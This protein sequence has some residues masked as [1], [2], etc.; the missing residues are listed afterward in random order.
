MAGLN[1]DVTSNNED[2]IKKSNQVR[3]EIGEV[4]KQME[5]EA[6]KMKAYDSEVLKMCDNLNK[7][8]DGLLGKINTM[9]SMLQAG[10]I[11][12]D[13]P[14]INIGSASTQQLDE[15]RSKNAEL[16]EQLR[17]Q[18]EEIKQQ[19]TE[20]NNLANAIKTNNV[21]AIEQYRQANAASTMGVKEAKAELKNLT[22]GLDENIKYYEKLTQQAAAYSEELVRLQAMKDKG[23]SRVVVGDNGVSVPVLDEIDKLTSKLSEVRANQK[24]IGSEIAAQRQQQIELNAVIEKGN[25]KHV[26]TRTLIMDAREQ[27]IQMRAAGLQNTVQ[28]QR[29]AEEL[30]KM[31]RQMILVNKE[32][33]FLANPNKNL[34][35][36]KA[37][38]TG[39]ATSASLIVGVMGL[40]NEKNEKMAEIQTKVQLL[41]AVVIGLEGTYGLLKKSNTVMLAIENLQRK[42]TISSMALETK[43][44]TTNIAL[45]WAEAAAQKALNTVA[46]A[47]PYLLLFGALLTLVGGIWLLVG[48]KREEI[49][50]QKETNKIMEEQ[51]KYHDKLKSRI[52]SLISVVRDSTSTE[53]ERVMA[54]KQLQTL[55]PALFK[56][57][58]IKTLKLREQNKLKKEIN[59][60]SDYA[61]IMGAKVKA[62]QAKNRY[63]SASAKHKKDI[64]DDLIGAGSLAEKNEAFMELQL[65]QSYLKNI[66]EIKA[67]ADKLKNV[68]KVK[69]KDFW[70]DQK[71]SAISVLDAIDS[72]QR[73]LLDE[74]AKS[75]KKNLYDLG[76]DKSIVDS[77]KQNIK[78]KKQAEKELKVYDDPTKQENAA[79][80]KAEELRKQQES[81]REQQDKNTQLEKKQSIDRQRQQQDLDNQVTQAGIDTLED[82][83]EKRQKQRELNNKKE[84]QTLERQ[85]EDYINAFIQ[86]EKDKFDA[87]ED[88]NAKQQKKYAKKTFDSSTVKV[89]TSAFDGIIGNVGKRQLND[90]IREQEDAWNE[91]LIKFGNYQQKRKALIEKYDKEIKEAITAGEAAT[92]EKEKQNA[93]DELDR[94]VKNST[95]LMGQL[96]ADASPKSA[97]E[98]QKIIE[99][100]ELLMQYLGAVKDA[101]GN[102]QI[103]GKTVSQKDILGL[104]ISE[105]TL[106]N[107][108]LSTEQV[109][110]L[111]NAIDRLKGDLGSK[112]PFKLFQT[113]VKEAVDKIGQGD[114][115]N[116]SQGISEIGA[117]VSSF[118]PA[119]AQFG[120]DLGNIVGSDDLGNKISGIA[121]AI[122]G[123]G[124][125]ATGVGQIMSGDIVGGR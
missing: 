19:Q 90:K 7:Y 62:I 95:T 32:M 10:K 77:Y 121:D 93:L 41:M 75:S 81:I 12:V 40:F 109:E 110:A 57:M 58:D 107:L 53:F 5:V 88:L 76:I 86:L 46:K 72:K 17:V 52:N 104:G 61:I 31:R 8:F 84:I 71:N 4:S 55:M 68:P 89:D 2:F 118:A 6:E 102:A 18:S 54:Y 125:T 42:A 120:K 14:T 9:N 124:Q 105:N 96:F 92:K 36:L 30:G 70:T 33:E 114:M 82:G 27:L 116:V 66:Q 67:E 21:S 91:Y 113:Q 87:Q 23:A 117:A 80:K 98:I 99:K 44:K 29:S 122:G 47:N 103:G 11:S 25:E 106:Q 94:S 48:A 97:S 59:E 60:Q 63:D 119:V 51:I 50:R 49:D 85:K 38:L 65:A 45:T 43:A 78:L 108:K 73:D 26:R 3:K 22:K 69:N 24:G 79:L 100:A 37:G 83:F 16:T 112:S 56:N 1:F 34:A 39:V 35:T 28:Y 15:F 13:S 101:Q 111:R 20:W 64:D 123:I 74:A 115:K